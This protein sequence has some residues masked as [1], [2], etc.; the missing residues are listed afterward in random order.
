MILFFVLVSYQLC[1]CL[2]YGFSSRLNRNGV[3]RIRVM[4]I[5]MSSVYKRFCYEEKGYN[6]FKSN[7]R[8]NEITNNN[9]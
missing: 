1:C 8:R 9:N 7:A 6:I 3:I 5:I 2:K 4:L